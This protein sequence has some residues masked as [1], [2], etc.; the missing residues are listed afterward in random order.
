MSRNEA[1]TG[2]TDIPVRPGV[3]GPVKA[4]KN[5]RDPAVGSPQLD[6]KR[7]QLH[8]G[9]TMNLRSTV[10]ALILLMIASR[11]AAASPSSSAQPSAADIAEI[12][13]LLRKVPLI[14]GHNDLPWQYRKHSN[15]FSAI[16][17][18]GD[19]RK[20]SPPLVT[21]I[22]RLRAGGVGAQFWAV[23][24][25][26]V[27]GGPPAV[28]MMFEQI[29]VV[30]QMVAHYPETFELALTAAD[31]ERIH[32][33]GKI[34]SLIGMEG[35]HSIN[36]S[37]AV[38]RMSYGLGARYLTLTHTKNTD[39]ADAAFDKPQH[40]GLSAFGEE[41]VREMNRLGMLVDLS[42]VTDET[43]RAALKVTKAPVIFSHSSAWGV[44][45]SP[46]NVPDDVLELTARNGGVVM[47]CFLPG[48]LTERGRLAMAASEAEKERL[49]KLY[50]D[51]PERFKQ[52]M[53]AW[54]QANPSPH[55][56]SLSDVAD[57]IDHVRKVAGIDHVGIG[58]DFEGF[59][60]APDGL[61]DVSC[62]PALLAE[63][64]RRGYSKPGLKKLAGLNF[65]RVMREV[66]KVSARLNG[67]AR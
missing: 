54:H 47:V 32:R 35:G 51:D 8:S 9:A 55:E 16:D 61:E 1:G 12:R 66:E 36:N 28:Q 53:A 41:V 44:C 2:S 42:H 7:S 48:Y 33:R 15:D 22:P 24:V 62:Y 14:D 57:H 11:G 40:H 38:L 63:L 21:D 23:Y 20:L 6:R 59:D 27:P 65:L 4:D 17:L 3:P 46:R 19:T 5:V 43:M 34:A 25:P 64:R 39:W 13:Q 49:R 60:G 18:R 10:G 29:D 31:I 37:L 26:P 67:Q 45:H 56:A 52:G 58:S 30:R 50:P